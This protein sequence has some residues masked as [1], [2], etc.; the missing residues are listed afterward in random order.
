MVPWLKAASAPRM[1]PRAKPSTAAGTASMSVLPSAFSSEAATGSLVTMEM[2]RSPRTMRPS[3]TAYCTCMGLSR[4]S[5]ARIW[6]A[7]SFGVSGGM[8]RSAASP[9]AILISAKTTIDT[10][11]RIGTA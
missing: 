7:T 11:I 1:V 2:P 4:P 10:P 5:L 6:A 3:Q 9:G 8:S